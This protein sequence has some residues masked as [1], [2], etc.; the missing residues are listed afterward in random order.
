MSKKVLIIDDNEQDRKIITRYLSQA[1][2]KDIVSA[3]TGA[4]GI[5]QASQ[6]NPDIIV[7]DTVLPGMDGFEICHE[8][9][10]VKKLKATVI[11]MTG[12]IDAV[13]ATKARKMGADDYCVKTSDCAVIIE[14]VKK[15]SSP[16]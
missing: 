15:A 3:E 13:D 9:K 14:A 2:F 5:A 7:L 8:I 11:M 1:G 10:H 6:N 16:A 12:R 4:D